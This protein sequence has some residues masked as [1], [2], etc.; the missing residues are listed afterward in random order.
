MIK[1]NP[2]ISGKVSPIDWD[3]YNK[4][5]DID[6]YK[7]DIHLIKM[8]G[9]QG[10]ESDQKKILQQREKEIKKIERIIKILQLNY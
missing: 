6:K 7:E 4:L 1:K 5:S 8:A 10:P 2:S 9:F 3:E